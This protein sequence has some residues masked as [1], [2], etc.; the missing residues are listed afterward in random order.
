MPNMDFIAG[1]VFAWLL[2]GFYK[3]IHTNVNG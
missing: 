3:L 1:F 2:I